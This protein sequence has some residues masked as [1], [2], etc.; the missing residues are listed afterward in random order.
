MILRHPMTTWS[1]YY[2]PANVGIVPLYYSVD[3]PRGYVP[4][5][6]PGAPWSIDYILP[7]FV[8]CRAP[9]S[10]PR[11]GPHCLNPESMVLPSSR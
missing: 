6:V 3:D 4:I 1:S 10:S 7:T 5:D 9:K 11:T 8:L 2:N